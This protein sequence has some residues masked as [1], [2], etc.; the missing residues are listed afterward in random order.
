MN[1]DLFDD[2]IDEEVTKESIKKDMEE[3]NRLGRV[4]VYSGTIGIVISLL[5]PLLGYLG[6][7][8]EM[9]AQMEFWVAMIASIPVFNLGL[10]FLAMGIMCGVGYDYQIMMY[11]LQMIY[12]NSQDEGDSQ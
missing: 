3:G 6:L 1:T 7:R 9:I 11:R 10:F 8:L 4:C 5:I 12:E 2:L